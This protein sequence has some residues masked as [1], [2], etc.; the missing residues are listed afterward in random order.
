M[1]L[2]F[3]KKT[4]SYMFFAGI[5]ISISFSFVQIPRCTL[6]IFDFFVCLNIVILPYLIVSDNRMNVSQ[7]TINQSVHHAKHKFALKMFYIYT[8]KGRIKILSKAL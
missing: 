7:H 2:D 4:I 5:H 1:E 8:S 6:C 3:A